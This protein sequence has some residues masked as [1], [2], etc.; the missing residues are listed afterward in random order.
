MLFTVFC[1][2]SEKLFDKFKWR[3][4]L[5]GINRIKQLLGGEWSIH[6]FVGVRQMK[7]GAYRGGERCAQGFGGEA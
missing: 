3:Y 4:Y 1:D 7:C 6:V 2:V 5:P